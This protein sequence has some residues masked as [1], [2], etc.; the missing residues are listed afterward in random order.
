M[1]DFILMMLESIFSI[2]FKFY[3]ILMTIFFLNN[4]ILAPVRGETVQSDFNIVKNKDINLTLGGSSMIS[5]SNKLL[6]LLCLAVCS[7]NPHCLTAV[8]DKNL[9]R[10]INCFKYDQY[11]QA[12]ELIPSSTRIVYEKK[13]SKLIKIYAPQLSCIVFFLIKF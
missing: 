7:S 4:L 13:R 5:S 12:S 1:K 2:C 10:L 3:M 8:Y 9:G 11:F 6:D